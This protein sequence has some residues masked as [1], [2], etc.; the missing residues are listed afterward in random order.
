MRFFFL[1]RVEDESG[2]SGTGIVAEGVVFSN[3]RCALNWLTDYE[4]QG[5]YP[6]IDELEAIHGHEG[7]TKVVFT[8][9]VSSK[10]LKELKEAAKAVKDLSKHLPKLIAAVEANPTF[11]K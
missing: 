11:K 6:S 10:E 5:I 8:P 9:G 7:K 4:S 1:H 3:G 2:V